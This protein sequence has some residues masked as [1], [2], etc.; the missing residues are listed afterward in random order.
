MGHPWNLYKV[1]NIESPSG[2]SKIIE[3]YTST[4]EPSC[5]PSGSPKGAEAVAFFQTVVKLFQVRRLCSK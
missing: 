3:F 5:L 2:R 1:G 4:L